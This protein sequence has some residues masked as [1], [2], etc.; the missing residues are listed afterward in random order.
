MSNEQLHS[1]TT[2]LIEAM[3]IDDELEH[4]TL[5]DLRNI[6]LHVAAVL[7]SNDD[8]DEVASEESDLKLFAKYV[9]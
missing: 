8:D 1:T 2:S 5:K 6:V 4:L 7:S 9:L 3:I